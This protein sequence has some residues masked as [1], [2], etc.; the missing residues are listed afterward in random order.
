MLKIVWEWRLLA[1]LYSNLINKLTRSIVK[2]RLVIRTMTDKRWVKVNPTG[3]GESLC[4]E[5]KYSVRDT[6]YIAMYLLRNWLHYTT[7]LSRL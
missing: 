1:I 6:E 3:I 4:C 7:S 2:G 5:D